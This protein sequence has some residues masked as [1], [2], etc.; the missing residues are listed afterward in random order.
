MATLYDILQVSQSAQEKDIKTAYKRLALRFHP[1]RNKDSESSTE[2]F[3]EISAAY[4]ILSNAAKRAAYD[5]H[6]H[7][8]QFQQSTTYSNHHSPYTADYIYPEYERRRARRSSFRRRDSYTKEDSI[9][10]DKMARKWII[11]AI[12]SIITTVVLF[13]YGNRY[14]QQRS[15]EALVERKDYVFTPLHTLI[16]NEKYA[17]AIQAS[18]AIA[19]EYTEFEI[20]AIRFKYQTL[21]SLK[22]KA[23]TAFEAGQ[24]SKVL[25]YLAPMRDLE[26]KELSSEL[27]YMLALSY[28]HLDRNM[29]AVGVLEYWVQK[30]PK[31][32]QAYVELAKLYDGEFKE[33]DIA[34]NYLNKASAFA[35]SYYK[36]KYGAAYAVVL[37]P[38]ELKEEH[39]D[40][41]LLRAKLLIKEGK[42]NDALK[43]A[44]WATFIRPNKAETYYILGKCY[45]GK[46]EKIQACM[47]WEKAYELNYDSAY[48]KLN[49]ECKG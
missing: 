11:F 43:D 16:E 19:N 26:L 22:D 29:E 35:T 28:K 41:Y 9:R 3:K 25:F 49:K 44:Q 40:L 8:L 36:S 7:Y 39:Y 17:E 42:Y 14:L 47:Q 48:A 33:T 15:Y 18:D 2:K 4:E 38:E 32:L 6:L 24:Y 27:F 31:N 46:G 21:N 30:D 34:I 12:L 10:E 45:A 5:V 20:H 1:D 37:S 13:T 23:K